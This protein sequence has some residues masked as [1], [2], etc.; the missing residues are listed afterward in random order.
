MLDVM[1]FQKYTLYSE[2]SFRNVPGSAF[3]DAYKFL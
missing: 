2:H 1:E 3:V